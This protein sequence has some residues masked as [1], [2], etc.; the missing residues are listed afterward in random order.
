MRKK[1]VRSFL[2]AFFILATGWWHLPLDDIQNLPDPRTSLAVRFPDAGI[3]AEL[4]EVF[5]DRFPL[6][7]DLAS[8]QLVTLIDFSRPSTEKRLWTFDPKTGALLFNSLVAHGQ[9][10]G[11]NMA[12]SFSNQ[13]NSHQS[14]LGF[15]LTDTPYKGK[16][17]LS[18][19]LI[20][21][22][23]GINNNALDRAIVVHGADYVSEQFVRQYG[24]LGRSHGC[25]ALPTEMVEP[26]VKATAKGTLIFIYHPEYQALLTKVEANTQVSQH[27]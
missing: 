27:L 12:V 21:L 3:S 7:S 24:R 9:G 11:E 14:S 17:G 2:I 15:F 4:R 26:F 25:P 5:N 16:H 23:P 1:I 19:R 13:P 20:G 6:F 8:H 10:T 22:E 18:L